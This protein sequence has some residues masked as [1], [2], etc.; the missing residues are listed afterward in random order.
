[1]KAVRKQEEEP[2]EHQP[3]TSDADEDESAEFS[4]YEFSVQHFQGYMSHRHIAQRL[5]Q[6]LLRH[7][8]EGD[9]RVR[10]RRPVRDARTLPPEAPSHCAPVALQ[11]CLTVGWIILRFMEDVPEPRAPESPI[12]QNMLH[13]R[14]RRLSNLAGLDQVPALDF[15]S[16]A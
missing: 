11:A 5:R 10:G 13:R 4:F 15:G 7:D 9:A 1:M 8:D 14:A 6:P 3:P 12:T 2:Q 16:F